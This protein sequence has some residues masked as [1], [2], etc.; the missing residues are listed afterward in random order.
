MIDWERD[1][2]M[3]GSLRE[4]SLSPHYLPGTLDVSLA[5]PFGYPFL[6]NLIHRAGCIV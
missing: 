1:P 6:P 5:L 4:I 2:R 3:G